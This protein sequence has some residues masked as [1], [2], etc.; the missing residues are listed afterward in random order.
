MACIVQ[1][2]SFPLSSC[3]IQGGVEASVFGL[4]KAQSV[5][6]E[7]HVFDVPRI[8]GSHVV[9]NMDGVVVHRFCNQGGRQFAA[10]RQ[11]VEMAKE[12]QALHPEVCH[13]HGTSLFAWLMYRELKRMKLHVIVT[14]HGLVRIEKFNALRK[15][16]SAKKIFQYLY[17][18]WVEKRFLSHLPAAIVDTEYVKSRVNQY[19]IRRKPVMHVIP[20]GIDETFF[21][22]KCSKDSRMILSVGAIGERK[23]HL[24]TLKAF[25]L[26]KDKGM[27]A[28]LVI[29]GTIADKHYLER[30]QNAIAQ[31][32]YKIQMSL[33][34]DI[35]DE[36]LK[37]LYEKAHLFVLHSEEESQGIVFAEAMATGLPIV[38]TQV[39]GIPWVVENGRNGLLSD[40]G[41][42]EAFAE[43]IQQLMSDTSLWQSMSDA[44][45][46]TAKVY[47]WHIISNRIIELYRLIR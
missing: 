46:E 15:G 9:E 31:S 43:N 11:T 1:I 21:S 33:Y 38:A 35:T 17:Q 16:I 12:I 22:V 19:P 37:K 14:V 45:S 4:A 24:F 41:D 30:L 20:Q 18:G 36:A 10:G 39:G 47:H 13:I 34:T 23:G 27:N 7:V 32:K 2:G 44:S 40:Y 26:A 5:T 3:R 25:E 29:V 8:G 42:V 28:Q 6:Y